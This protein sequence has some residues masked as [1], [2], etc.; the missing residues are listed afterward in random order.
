MEN[1]SRPSQCDRLLTYLKSGKCITSLQAFN[2][3]GIVRLGSRIHELKKRR[4]DIKEKWII[5]TN[6]FGEKCRVK[7]FYLEGN[8][9][10][11]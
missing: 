2:E 9:A 6:R 8:D 4:D 7:G 5:V 1:N 11:M 10:E 3:L